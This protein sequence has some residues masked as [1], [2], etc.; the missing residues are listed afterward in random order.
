MNHW[1]HTT[2]GLELTGEELQTLVD[3]LQASTDEGVADVRERLQQ[4]LLRARAQPTTSHAP[5][6]VEARYHP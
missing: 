5:M 3:S 6:S 1:F 4:A 2:V